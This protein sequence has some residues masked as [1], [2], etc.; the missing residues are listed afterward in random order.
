MGAIVVLGIMLATNHVEAQKKVVVVPLLGD[1]SLWQKKG[2]DIYYS[3]GNVGIGTANP[4]APL[5]IAAD[6]GGAS[7]LLEGSIQFNSNIHGGNNNL[8]S[9]ISTLPGEPNASSITFTT[10]DGSGQI[11]RVRI[12]PEGNVGIGTTSPQAPLHIGSSVGPDSVSLLAAGLGRFMMGL[13]VDQNI[14]GGTNNNL[15]LISTLPN[16][17]NRSSITLTTSDGFSP[18]ERVR[19]TPEGNVG[20]GTT[21]PASGYKLDVE[22]KIQASSF[23]TG[24]ITFRKNGEILWRMFE[25]HD[26][27]YLENVKTSKVYLL[28]MQEP[29]ATLTSV[30]QLQLKNQ[31]LEK[32]LARLESLILE[33]K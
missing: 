32:R 33:K 5:H 24:D 13:Q 22:G 15:S 28:F 8:L 23:D 16:L 31:E 10:G 9:L 3:A 18:N 6:A 2:S 25:E 14:H 17:D 30:G 19:I 7:L 29:E 4:Q 20:I 1:D 27:L 11:E 26:G 21:S 12:T